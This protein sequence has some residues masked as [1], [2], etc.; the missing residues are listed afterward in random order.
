MRNVLITFGIIVLVAWISAG[1]VMGQYNSMVAGNETV[2]NRWAA[3]EAQYQRRF[4]LVP[5]LVAATQGYLQHE[6]KVYDDIAEARTHY[7]GAPVNSN[8]RVQAMQT[9]ESALARLMVIVENYPTLQGLP[10]VRALTDEVTGTENRI[11][12]ARDRYNESV[13]EWNTNIKRVPRAWFASWFG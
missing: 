10:A 5:N 8:E 12:V 11:T 1:Y 9:Y 7:A 4:D 3:V 2:D 6:R 13:R